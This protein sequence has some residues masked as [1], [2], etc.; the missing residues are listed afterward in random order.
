M[1]DIIKR[2]FNNSHET[3]Y[4]VVGYSIIF[5]ISL[6]F[7]YFI[8]K[9]V[10]W[11]IGD[12][13]QFLV[14]T[15][16]GKT[17]VVGDSIGGRYWPLGFF[18]YN[19]LVFIPGGHTVL[20]HYIYVAITFGL[21]ILLFVALL[22]RILQSNKYVPCLIAYC[23]ILL[24][25]TA[26]FCRI[27]M[28][29]IFPERIIIL[30]LLIFMH[31][32]LYALETQKAIYYFSAFC[33]AIYTTYCKEPIFGLFATIAATN[34]IFG[35]R[36]L[37]ENRRYIYFN[38]AL[39]LNAIVYFSQWYCYA[40]RNTTAFYG[41]YYRRS[42]ERIIFFTE[43][44]LIFVFIFAFVR[45]YFI[46]FKKD[47]DHLYLDS[48]L[49][50]AAAYALAFV[51]LR[52]ADGHYFIPSILLAIPSFAYWVNHGILRKKILHVIIVVTVGSSWEM[53]NNL[54]ITKYFFKTTLE[55]RISDMNTVE[56]IC[57][58]SKSLEIPIYFY[59]NKNVH[60]SDY[61]RIVWNDFLEY[62]TKDKGIAADI[63]EP[64]S[65]P[66]RGIILY[67]TT[68]VNDVSI[69]RE[70]TAKNFRLLKRKAVTNIYICE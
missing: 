42:I 23:F 70:L 43:C 64:H 3:I 49:F 48:L 60:Y 17:G 47:R 4:G 5:L 7:I 33:V 1:L 24:M 65:L 32:Y 30:L 6:I 38:Y 27:F 10:N 69:A 14:S 45:L 40:F 15:A 41:E 51:I 20:G 55:R 54:P 8:L 21:S 63:S 12:D 36:N 56:N 57:A 11:I 67:P 13:R 18:D 53:Y 61:M 31:C 28:E 26:G 46:I 19:I 52:L 16:I 2:R 66:D 59:K 22:E 9:D 35:N 39:I 29:V 25:L 44:L 37:S 62:T 68:N 50:A 58:L 34:L